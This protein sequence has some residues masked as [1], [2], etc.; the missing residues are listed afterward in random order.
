MREAYGGTW[1]TG[2]VIL[3]TFV[4]SAFLA[5][6]INY[7]KAFRVKNEV[8]SI[9]EKKGGATDEAITLINNYLENNNYHL[10]GDC[11]D[12]DYG[13]KAQANDGKIGTAAKGTKYS[14]CISKIKSKGPNFQD[15]AYYEVKLFFK[16]N[17]PVIGDIFTFDVKGQTKD[18]SYPLDGK[19]GA[20]GRIAKCRTKME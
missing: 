2:L 4:F 14:Y 5:L 20:G 6:S 12:F 9:L 1:I 17:L 8:L 18:V 16:F 3:F 13:V 15:R 7:S 10:V 19:C 11:K